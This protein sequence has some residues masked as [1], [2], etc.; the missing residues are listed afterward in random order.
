ML[1]KK[2]SAVTPSMSRCSW[3]GHFCPYRLSVRT[4]DFHS[5]KRSSILRG[6][7]TFCEH[8]ST[9][10]ER[11]ASNQEVGGSSPPVRTIFRGVLAQW[12]E[13]RPFKSLVSGSSP[14]H[15]TIS[16]SAGGRA[17]IARDCKSR[18]LTDYHGSSPCRR[19]IFG[20][21]NENTGASLTFCGTIAQ[22]GRAPRS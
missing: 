20:I 9:G 12:P 5:S 14:E 17:A 13:Q 16:V 2:H 11:L 8:S 18:V 21:I 6:G 4:E 1:L 7:A 19:T 22:L 15:P 3:A 10:P